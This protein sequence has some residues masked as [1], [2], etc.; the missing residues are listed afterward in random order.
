MVWSVNDILLHYTEQHHDTI[1]VALANI[2]PTPIILNA[3]MEHCFGTDS[4]DY[5]FTCHT[6]AQ[7]DIFNTSSFLYRYCVGEK[8]LQQG[9]TS[10]TN[11]YG[12]IGQLSNGTF[13]TKR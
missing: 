7:S 10:S 12:L 1:E 2:P 5:L 11:T 3:S 8:R 13:S 6:N 4:N 9:Y